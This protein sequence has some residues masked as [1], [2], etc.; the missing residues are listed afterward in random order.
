L[1]LLGGRNVAHDQAGSLGCR[2]TVVM[3]LH[4][5]HRGSISDACFKAPIHWPGI[6]VFPCQ[7]IFWP[8]GLLVFS[9]AI[10]GCA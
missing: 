6:F 10:F 2:I 1:F 7:A 9:E 3:S 4:A 8:I 5:F